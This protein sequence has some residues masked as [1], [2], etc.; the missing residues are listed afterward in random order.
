MPGLL[1]LLQDDEPAVRA[2]AAQALGALG[3]A[4]PRVAMEVRAWK[5]HRARIVW[6]RLASVCM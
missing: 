1:A 2:A 6:R 4:A 3:Q 5:R